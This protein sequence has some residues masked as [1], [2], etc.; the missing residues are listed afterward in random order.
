MRRAEEQA[1]FAQDRVGAD[2]AD[3]VSE[4][5]AARQRVVV[6]RREVE[7]AAQ[8]EAAE[9][10]R[11]DAGDSTLLFVNL[12]EVATAE[13]RIREVDALADVHRAAASLRA[14]MAVDISEVD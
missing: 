1:R 7:L 14:A 4:V 2:V 13:A 9:R 12:R 8:L 10:R 5:D 3:A 11:F 6:V